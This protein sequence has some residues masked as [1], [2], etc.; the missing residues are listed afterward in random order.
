MDMHMRKILK[1]NYLIASLVGV[2]TFIVYLPALRNE[3]INW[4]DKAYVYEN[5]FIRSL[6]TGLLRSAFLN[7]HASNWHPLTWISHAIDYSIWGLDP[8]G[9]HLTNTILHALNTFLVVVL[10]MKLLASRQADRLTGSHYSLFIAAGVTGVLFG[11]HP[12]HVESV[13]WVAERKDL[14]C[15]FFFLLSIMAYAKYASRASHEASGIAQGVNNNTQGGGHRKQGAVTPVPGPLRPFKG[16][17]LSALCFF[18][19]ALLSKP[20]AVSLPFVLLILDW[21]P[22]RRIQSLKALWTAS[23]EKLPFF[24]LTIASSILTMRAQEAGEAITSVEVIPLTSRVI[25]AAKS[26]TVYLVKMMVPLHLVPFYPYPQNI[27]LF[28]FAHSVPIVIVAGITA[29]CIAVMRKEKLWMSVWSYYVI[30]L[31]PVLGFVQV[32]LQSM[33]DRYTYLP[34]LGPFL[35]IGVITAKGYQKVSALTRRRAILRIAGMALALAIAL[36]LSYSTIKQIGIWKDT[37]VFWN[38]VI[39]KEPGVPLAHNNL[40]AAYLSKGL[41]DTAIAHYQTALRL[42]PDD[43]EAHNN[44]GNAY[45]LKGLFDTAIAHYQTALRLKPDL[46]EAHNNLG[47]A[48]KSKGLLDMAITHYQSALRLKPDYVKAHY[49]LGN[50]YSSKGLHDMA[51]THYQSALRLKPDYAE[52]HFN[53]GLIYLNSGFLDK[54]R[55]EF[56]EVLRI[57][58]DDYGA[59]QILN[60]MISR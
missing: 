10:V 25:V 34:S 18:I 55:T 14:L 17:L 29:T 44:L 27:S 28:S 32:G 60:S 53:L 13:A 59:R 57:R 15:A 4:D 12:L 35:I 3:F 38:Y 41:Y 37:V 8:L 21:Y 7:F 58:P 49:N 45:S 23:I 19:L 26:L 43:A 51:I 6:D 5:P 48:Y 46:A 33:A 20:M 50:A 39:D 16:S 40:G 11:L 36:S 1:T 9:H 42:K 52:A 56:E 47:I 24:A 30:T 54:A 31:I 22:F 2:V